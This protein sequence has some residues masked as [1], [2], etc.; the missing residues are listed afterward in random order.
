VARRA[1]SF[2][3]AMTNRA[4]DDREV[5]VKA[6]PAA[7]RVK[8]FELFERG[9]CSPAA[10]LR[11]PRY[12]ATVEGRGT[13]SLIMRRAPARTCASSRSAGGCHRPSC[14]TC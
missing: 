5:I 1:R 3:R 13:F 12:F 4:A 6:V 9:Q 14:E 8:S 2:S 7:R 10:P 11:V